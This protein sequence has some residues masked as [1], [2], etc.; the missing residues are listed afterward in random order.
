MK[1]TT[2]IFV[3]AQQPYR[4]DRPFIQPLPIWDYWY[5]LLVPLVLAISVVYKSVRCSSMRRVPR[6][7]LVLFVF[8]MTVMLLAAGALAALVNVVK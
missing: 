7:A 8:I 2:L 1:L 6:E 5:V 4:Y 3:L